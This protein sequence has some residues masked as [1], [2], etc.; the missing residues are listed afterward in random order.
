ML[1][2]KKILSRIVKYFLVNSSGFIIDLVLIWWLTDKIK[3]HYLTSVAV[4]FL[5]ATVINYLGNREWTF[6]GTAIKAT[7]GYGRFL[8]ISLGAF[9]V[10]LFLMYLA[11]D[12]LQIY[13]LLARVMVAIIVGL[14]GFL[15]DAKFSFG[16]PI[17]LKRLW[18]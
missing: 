13:Y 8:M 18:H 5:V 16:M 15:L 10:V 7:V 4:G 11:V 9:I 17:H 6:K 14:L 1:A 2:I 12:I 3:L